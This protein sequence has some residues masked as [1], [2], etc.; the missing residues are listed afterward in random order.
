M[1]PVSKGRNNQ[2]IDVS[3]NVVHGLAML[4]RG[5]WQLGFEVTWLDLCKNGQIFD[6]V[7][8]IGDPVDQF[9]TVATKLFSG[10]IAGGFL[11]LRFSRHQFGRPGLEPPRSTKLKTP[12]AVTVVARYLR[13]TSSRPR[14]AGDARSAGA[15]YTSQSAPG[16]PVG[17]R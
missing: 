11:D 14:A 4:R 1:T 3:E 7:E 10:H 9:M 5:G 17:H 2:A 15:R 13:K 16:G 6:M 8:V 12:A